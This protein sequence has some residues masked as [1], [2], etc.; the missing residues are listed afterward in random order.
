MA[1]IP[2]HTAMKVSMV[3]FNPF[4]FCLTVKSAVKFG[5][6]SPALFHCVNFPSTYCSQYVFVANGFF[7]NHHETVAENR[8]PIAL[9]AQALLLKRIYSSICKLFLSTNFAALDESGAPRLPSTVPLESPRESVARF[10][11]F[12]VNVPKIPQPCKKISDAINRNLIPSLSAFDSLCQD[13][14]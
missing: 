11:S 13:P 3:R 8:P 14:L 7:G 5:D 12:L 4:H 9:M 6:Q 2:T 1:K 10:F